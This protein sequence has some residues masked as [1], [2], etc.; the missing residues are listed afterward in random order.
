[1]TSV[2]LGASTP[3]QLEENLQ[4]VAV[5]KALT[6]E[7]R[8]EIDAVLGM[9]AVDASKQARKIA[10]TL[11]KAEAAVEAREE[12]R[13]EAQEEAREEVAAEPRAFAAES[14]PKSGADSWEESSRAESPAESSRAES[15]AGSSAP[16]TRPTSAAPSEAPSMTASEAA[17][18]VLNQ[19][20]EDIAAEMSPHVEVEE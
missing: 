10:L 16:G 12:T 5:A 2:I 7:L 20:A 14:L 17:E 6:P 4:A 11:P 3:A 19:T 15:P 1:M 8:A 13:E 18:Q 9:D